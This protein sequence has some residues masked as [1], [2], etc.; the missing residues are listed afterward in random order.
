MRR[1]V[2]GLTTLAVAAAQASGSVPRPQ[3]AAASTQRPGAQVRARC[4]T[5]GDSLRRVL[6]IRLDSLRGEFERRSLT[7]EQNEVLTREMTETLIALQRFFEEGGGPR[8]RTA[9]QGGEVAAYSFQFQTG[10]KRGYLGV[11][12]DG[13]SA[14]R[15]KSVV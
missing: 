10:P 12:F 15:S 7:N 13:P 1:L 5:C 4:A 11:V 8:R 2:L 14:E 9:P 3:A 6:I